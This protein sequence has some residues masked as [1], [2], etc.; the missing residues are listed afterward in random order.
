M[1]YCY[2]IIFLLATTHARIK[3]RNTNHPVNINIYLETLLDPEDSILKTY[4][5]VAMN[6]QTLRIYD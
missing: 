1:K 3:K 5:Q 6:L 4:R 2:L